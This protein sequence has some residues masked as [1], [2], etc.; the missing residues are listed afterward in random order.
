MIES[1]HTI[2]KTV[3][4][5]AMLENQTIEGATGSEEREIWLPKH[6]QHYTGP[7][8]LVEERSHWN[9]LEKRDSDG[10]DD[11]HELIWDTE[12]H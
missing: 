2:P 9:D 7:K 12:K 11:E 6:A 8:Q 4:S 5:A 3:P 1:T 10:S